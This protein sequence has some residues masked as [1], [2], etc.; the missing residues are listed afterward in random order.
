MRNWVRMTVGIAFVFHIVTG[1]LCF[2]AEMSN[3]A[4]FSDP[5][6]IH[7]PEGKF[8]TALL[9]LA[10]DAKAFSPYAFLVDKK[11]RTLTVWESLQDSLHLVGA[12]PTDIGSRDGDKLVQGDGKT[13]EG[14]YFF[15]ATMDGRQVNF[16]QYGARIFTLDYPNYFDRLEKKTG[17]GIWFHAIPESKS[18]QRGS[19][20]CVVVRNKAIEELGKL[21]ELKRTPMLIVSEV[22]YV[23]PSDWRKMRQEL[24][25]WLDGWRKSWVGK[26]LNAYMAQ[27]SDRFHTMGMNKKGWR[28]Y[29][30][31]LAGRYKFIDVSLRDVQI[32]NQGAKVVFRFLQDYK[33][34]Q[35]QDL[36]EK[37][38]YAQKKEGG[39]EI[40]GETW[41]PSKEASSM[42]FQGLSSK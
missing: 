22:S 35:K 40:V 6:A 11:T 7:P 39:F 23:T 20:G 17:N 24:T 41:L 31:S 3:N 9:S 19:R 13:P 14:I 33:S 4:Q 25:S 27:Y 36:G 2:A 29:K 18:L 8:P 38:I 30:E 10:S 1:V 37:M 21:I 32:F 15:Q 5:A 26:D 16:D 34:D 12:W 28:A 42:G